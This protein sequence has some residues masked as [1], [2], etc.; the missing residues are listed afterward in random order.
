MLRL[1]TVPNA[2]QAIPHLE[3]PAA[4]EQAALRVSF[5]GTQ[6]IQT[7]QTLFAAEP[8]YTF[9]D[10][11]GKHAHFELEMVRKLMSTFQIV[12]ASRKRFSNNRSCLLQ[13][14]LKSNPRVE[15]MNALAKICECCAH[16]RVG[17]IRST[18]RIRSAK[19]RSATCVYRVSSRPQTASVARLTCAVN[20]ID[21]IEPGKKGS[22]S[23][24]VRLRPNNDL[25]AQ[26]KTLQIKF[27]EESGRCHCGVA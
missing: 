15:A 10:E 8:S 26:M 25:L 5:L 9:E 6:T 19:R 20:S 11:K 23:M 18:L 2:R 4:S 13:V 24:T 3:Q 22:K 7:A 21:R 16:R 1:D 27:L 14:W 17:S 12:Y